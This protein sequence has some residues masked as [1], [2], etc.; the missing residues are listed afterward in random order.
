[1]QNL[2]LKLKCENN[3]FIKMDSSQDMFLSESDT[4]EGGTSGEEGG[5]DESQI[6]KYPYALDPCFESKEEMEEY[7]RSIGQVDVVRTRGER[8]LVEVRE[9]SLRD[10]SCGEC[11]D[12]SDTE[13]FQYLC[14]HQ[15]F[16][17]WKSLCLETENV[18][19]VVKTKV[20]SE[21]HH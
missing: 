5:K 14:C 8:A 4:L 3:S 18:A 10:C 16:P 12:S 20:K 17:Q 11:G 1:M 21:V 15:L 7:L 6:V 13:G 2:A 19:C 9:G